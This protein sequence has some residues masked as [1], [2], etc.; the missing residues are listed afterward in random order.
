MFIHITLAGRKFSS[1]ALPT[2]H[3]IYIYTDVYLGLN[4][5]PNSCIRIYIFGELR[6]ATMVK[7]FDGVEV[8]K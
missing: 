8:E 7:V 5:F 1:G 3:S 2:M 6:M 4:F